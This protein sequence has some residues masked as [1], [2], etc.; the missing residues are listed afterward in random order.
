VGTNKGR[1]RVHL[2]AGARVAASRAKRGLRKVTVDIPIGSH[3]HILTFARLLREM[4][5]AGHEFPRF[6]PT[7]RTTGW[8][9]NEVGESST[10]LTTIFKLGD[11]FTAE[12]EFGYSDRDYEWQCEVR[13]TDVGSSRGMSIF[14]AHGS[15]SNYGLASDL[16][17]LIFPLWAG[18]Y[19]ARQKKP[20]MKPQPSL[21]SLRAL[22]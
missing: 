19:F 20:S 2:N 9:R 1:P 15:S 17:E 16:A 11:R 10:R 12:V 5:L 4:D 14:R 3:N 21:G 13:K 7:S 6:Q 18:R 22:R 8:S